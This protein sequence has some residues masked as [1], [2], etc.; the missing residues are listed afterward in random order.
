MT[1]APINVEEPRRRPMTGSPARSDRGLAVGAAWGAAVGV[2]VAMVGFLGTSV[3]DLLVG[4]VLGGLLLALVDGVV[5]V[6]RSLV[7]VAGR[8]TLPGLADRLGCTRTMR[9]SWPLTGVVLV[10]GPW[11]APDSP[12]A[13]LNAHA[14]GSIVIVVAI[15]AGAAL[16][17]ARHRPPG[18]ARASVT[19]VTV[20]IALGPLVWLAHPGPGTGTV[21]APASV[22]ESTLDLVDPGTPGPYTVGTATYGSGVN[23]HRPAFGPDATA[24]TEPIDGRG[25]PP[26]FGWAHRLHIRLATGATLDRLPIDG[27]VW[28]PVGV[29]R[30]PLVLVV[31]GNHAL[32]RASDPGYAYLGRHLASRG[33]VVVSIDQNFLNGSLA[34]DGDGAEHPLRARVL[35]EHLRQWAAWGAGGGPIPGGVDLERVALIGHSRGGEAVAH[36]AAIAGDRPRSLAPTWPTFDD[37]VR[38]RGVVAIMPSDGQ[39]QNG[40]PRRLEGPSYLVLGAG[41]DGDATTWQGLAQ[42]HRTELAE[43]P[44]SFAAYAYL[45][46]AN[47]GQ[48]NTVW[49]RDDQGWLN[50]TI[51]DRG[52]LLP[53]EEQRRAT[54]T[55]VTAFL[56]AA[57][58]GADGNRAVFIRPDAAR[59]WL[60]DDVVVTGYRDGTTRPLR[61]FRADTGVRADDRDATVDVVRLPARDGE[62]PLGTRAVRIGWQDGPGPPLRFPVSEDSARRRPSDVLSVAYGGADL[63]VPPR[64]TVELE[65]ADGDRAAL[66]V[67][68]TTALRPPLPARVAKLPAFAAR[69]RVPADFAWPAEHLL[70]THELPLAAFTDE[71]PALDLQRLATVTLRPEASGPA[72]IHIGEVAF[73]QRTN[74]EIA[75][76]GDRDP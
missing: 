21:T 41:L 53:G 51:L 29:A 37:S 46:R 32:H 68:L 28:Y 24:R 1:V 49:G 16:G 11:V 63:A 27:T 4:L 60:P 31:H 3:W 57:L 52:G 67:D 6:L 71:S 44:S 34:G 58:L 38:I 76:T 19:A 35:L 69:Y 65:D 40:S 45:Q 64:L 47:H 48:A 33:Y 39:W 70:Q 20:A 9:L 12:L 66:P 30:P 74:A 14:A 8:R 43:D 13:I 18:P 72:V 26:A 17:W 50:S 10:V 55:L 7:R 73:R 36:A 23:P 15:V 54:R 5:T 75:A 61:R 42:Y 59:A 25:V 2:I 62:R 56:D 22:A